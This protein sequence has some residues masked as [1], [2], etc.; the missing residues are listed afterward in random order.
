MCE[1]VRQMKI[2]LIYRQD[3]VI[4]SNLQSPFLKYMCFNVKPLMT[5]RLIVYYTKTNT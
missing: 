2:Q 4:V 1:N 3:K 5:K